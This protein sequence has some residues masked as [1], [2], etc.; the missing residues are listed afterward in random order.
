VLRIVCQFLLILFCFF[1]NLEVKA[2]E[3]LGSAEVHDLNFDPLN[4]YSTVP[5]SYFVFNPNKDISRRRQQIIKS[6]GSSADYLISAKYLTDPLEPDFRRIAWILCDQK[7]LKI[8]YRMSPDKTFS[9]IYQRSC[10]H[11]QNLHSQ[12][13]YSE[14]GLLQYSQDFSK[15]SEFEKQD[16]ELMRE[17][18][19]GMLKTPSD[20]GTFS[21]HHGHKTNKVF[22]YIHGFMK[23]SEWFLKSAEEMYYQGHN[24]LLLTLPGFENQMVGKGPFA[25]Q[26]ISYTEISA[27]VAQKYGDEVIVVGHSLGGNLALRLAEQGLTQKLILIHPLIKTTEMA[28]S[29]FNFSRKLSYKNQN[30]LGFITSIGFRKGTKVQELLP[31]VTEVL[32]IERLPFPPFSQDLKTFVFISHIDYAASTSA[33][34][35]FLKKYLPHAQVKYNYSTHM[36]EPSLQ[37][38]KDDEVQKFIDF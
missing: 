36:S 38:W 16:F 28:R 23:N 12:I 4:K 18:N 30:L 32:K 6:G 10:D 7:K 21:L 17:M 27:L 29:T 9:K 35:S 31:L 3:A 15:L 2:Q 13:T 5:S 14:N 24:V 11:I 26:W 25:N 34:I 8:Q 33:T 37:F 22:V 20:Y 19:Q 1:V